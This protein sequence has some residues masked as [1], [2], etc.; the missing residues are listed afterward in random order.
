MRSAFNF[1]P[2]T[3][4][5]GQQPSAEQRLARLVMLNGIDPRRAHQELAADPEV[6]QLLV[7]N[8]KR[9]TY[10]QPLPGGFASAGATNEFPQPGTPAA[11]SGGR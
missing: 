4:L 2:K 8:K 1:D 3:V 6:Q 11:G 5:R 9:Q 10:R 7:A